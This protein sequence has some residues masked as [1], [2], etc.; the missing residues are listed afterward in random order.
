MRIL[1]IDPSMGAAGDM[2]TAALME[3]LENPN[4]F[5]EEMQALGLDGVEFSSHP[6]EKC[7]IMGTSVQVKVHGVEEESHDH[8]G[9]HVHDHEHEHSYDHDHNHKHTHDHD[10]THGHHHN[11]LHSIGHIVEKL[12]VSEKVKEDVMGVY[13]LIGEAE[14]RAHGVPVTQ[15]HFH[16]VGEMDAITDITAV[17]LLM[18]KIGPEKVIA[19]PI[20]VGSGH[21][22]CAHGVLPV[23]APATAFILEGIPMY[24]GE[25]QGE[26]CTPTGAALLK[27]YVDEFGPMPPMRTEKIGYGMGKKDFPRANT[28]RVLLGEMENDKEEVILLE[29]NIDDMTPEALGF[30]MEHLLEFSLDVWFTP[31]QMKKSRP[32]TL[33]SVLCERDQKESCIEKIFRY[34]TTIGVRE[35]AYT[36]HTLKRKVMEETTASGNIRKKVASGYGVTRTKYEYD[37]VRKIALIE[38]KDIDTIR[39]DLCMDATDESIS[40]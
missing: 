5:V 30:A 29:A 33:I 6:A 36:R 18:E 17:C 37:D 40:L 19:S 22:H 8:H 7:G 38:E 31:V 11:D 20:H 10:H 9:H 12:P 24:G 26:L 16:E 28:L 2:L 35:S 1:Y 4:E 27:H 21:V 39:K 15:I 34:T 13:T 25:I 32:G 14:S 3:L 23:P